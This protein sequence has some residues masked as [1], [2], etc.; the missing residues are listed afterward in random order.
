MARTNASFAIPV[1]AAFVTAQA[2]AAEMNRATAEVWQVYVRGTGARMQTRLE[3]SKPFL[4]MEEAADRARPVKRG[5]I[6]LAPNEDLLN[7][8]YDYDRY[9]D[10]YRPAGTDSRSFGV[11]GAKQEVWQ[12]HI[13]FLNAAMRGRCRAHDMTFDSHC[14]YSIVETTTLQQ[15]ERPGEHL[16]P[17]DAGSGFIWAIDSIVQYEP[18]DGGVHLEI[19]GIALTRD[20][21]SSMRLLVD[22]LVSHLSVSSLTTTLPQAGEAV[23]RHEVAQERLAARKHQGL[24]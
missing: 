12:K 6:V 21:P 19:E 16:A 17:P 1:I 20:V 24:N 9:K 18:Q 22:P 13:P 5:E 4:W 8:V 7:A 14:G 11:G 23:D 2:H 10:I 15:I 3:G